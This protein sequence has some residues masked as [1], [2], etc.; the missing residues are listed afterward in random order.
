M[1]KNSNIDSIGG[2]EF[3]TFKLKEGVTEATLVELSKQVEIEFLSQQEELVLHFL[4]RGTDG[5]YADVAIASSQEK[6]E[7]YCQQWL[8]NKVALEYLELIDEESVN[9]TFWRRIN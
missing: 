2:M 5:I 3:A 9:M 1:I 4:V 7:E 8:N 6:A